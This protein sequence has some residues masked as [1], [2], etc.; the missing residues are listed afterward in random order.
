MKFFRCEHCG[1]IVTHLE[2]SGVFLVCCGEPMKEL[3]PG[4]TDAAKEKHVP[5]VEVEGDKVNVKVGEV[6]HP[7][8]KEHLIQWIVL[9]TNKGFHVRKLTPED[10]P[11]ACFTLNDEK[12]VAAYE[13]CNLHGLWKKE[14]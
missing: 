13:Y 1:N 2:D 3:V 12:A 8:T 7:M 11:A 5:V 6:P 10:E 4:T 14:I 9:E